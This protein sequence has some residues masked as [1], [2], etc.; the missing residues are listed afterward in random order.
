MLFLS[1]LSRTTIFVG[2]LESIHTYIHTMAGPDNDGNSG[3]RGRSSNIQQSSRKEGGQSRR[4]G[5]SSRKAVV[6]DG[7]GTLPAEEGESEEHCD[8]GS[9]HFLKKSAMFVRPGTKPAKKKL[10]KPKAKPSKSTGNTL[11]NTPRAQHLRSILVVARKDNVQPSAVV[12]APANIEGTHGVTENDSMDIS[13]G[14]LRTHEIMS[15]MLINDG[16]RLA[17]LY[18]T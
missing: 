17:A 8:T 7:G 4:K 6:G 13:S 3:T 16:V 15:A 1:H 5:S 10:P 9:C 2:P 14:G 11:Y 12:P 18:L